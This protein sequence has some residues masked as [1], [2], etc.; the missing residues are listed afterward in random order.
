MACI[1]LLVTI[2][3]DVIQDGL[4]IKVFVAGVGSFLKQQLHHL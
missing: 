3:S 2:A 1:I 4:P